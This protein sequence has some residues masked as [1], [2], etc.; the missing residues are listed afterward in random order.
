ARQREKGTNS[1]QSEGWRRFGSGA[2][3]DQP[4]SSGQAPARGTLA[5]PADGN[6]TEKPAPSDGQ[7]WRRFSGSSPAQHNGALSR[8]P[9]RSSAEP[10]P[11]AP[12]LEKSP[13]PDSP[14]NDSWRT[15]H[16]RP[17]RAVQQS[18]R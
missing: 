2:T 17:Q 11:N 8:T 9:E 18:P 1:S 6:R 14:S 16:A 12:H 15:F 4:A 10:G 3:Q 13:K 5:L 7:S